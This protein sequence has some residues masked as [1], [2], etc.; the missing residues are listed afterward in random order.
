VKDANGNVCTAFAG[1]VSLGILTGTGTAGAALNGAATVIPVNGVAAFSGLSINKAGTGYELAATSEGL[2]PANS[3]PFSVDVVP[4]KLVVLTQPAPS[5]A[6]EVFRTQPVFAAQD[7]AGNLAPSFS[8]PVSVS[9]LAGT[10]YPGATLGGTTIVNAV[11]GVAAFTG[12]S[13]DKVGYAYRLTATSGSLAPANTVGFDI[14]TTA[15]KLAFETQPGGAKSGRPFAVQPVIVALNAAGTPALDYVGT[16]V[17]GIKDGAG[18][19]TA[20]LEGTTAVDFV[21]GRAAFPDLSISDPGSGYVLAADSGT[22]PM[23]ESAPFDVVYGGPFTLNDAIRAASLAGGL[24]TA[25]SADITRLDVDMPAGVDLL[26]A[27]RIMRK[28]SGL[29]PNP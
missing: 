19:S 2:P 10:G 1:T 8:G 17:V 23:A 28:V 4:T 6:G 22:L 26:D 11:N 9:I 12:L 18:A 3:A 20:Y 16:A 25:T 15:V 13:I 5:N 7:D 21:S 14:A 29:E 24:D 27:A